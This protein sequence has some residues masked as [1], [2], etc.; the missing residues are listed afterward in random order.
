MRDLSPLC[1]LECQAKLAACTGNATA[2][3]NAQP[4][5]SPASKCFIT[6]KAQTQFRGLYG[7]VHQQACPLKG[8]V[9]HDKL[10]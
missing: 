1:C 8:K 3:I 4:S 10:K 2:C 5:L 6:A 7:A 9:K